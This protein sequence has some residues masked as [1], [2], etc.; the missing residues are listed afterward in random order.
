MAED[1]AKEAKD[2][3]AS[4][5]PGLKDQAA[6]KVSEAKDKVDE[7]TSPNQ[8]QRIEDKAAEL[9]DKTV[10]G[11][12]ELKDTVSNAYE[13]KNKLMPP[14]PSFSSV[15]PPTM[16]LALPPLFYPS[17]T[18]TL[19]YASAGR[20]LGYPAILPSTSPLLYILSFFI[21]H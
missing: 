14:S 4:K 7:A 15:L 3:V 2:T 20:A 9:K 21:S 5:A 8:L 1:K 12:H 6:S 16:P 19:M 10:Q 17:R 11:V 13:E 18:S